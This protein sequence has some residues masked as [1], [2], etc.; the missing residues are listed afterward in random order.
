VRQIH[1]ER[2]VAGRAVAILQ[3]IHLSSS[4]SLL[5]SW[6]ALT[7]LIIALLQA[8]PAGELEIAGLREAGPCLAGQG[9]LLGY[10]CGILWYAGTSLLDLR[11]DGVNTAGLSAAEALLALFLSVAIWVSITAC[12]ALLVTL[13][14]GSGRDFRRPL[15]MAPFL[16]GG[17]GTG[18]HPG[19]G[20]SRESAGIAQVDN[21]ALCRINGVD[22]SLRDLAGD[23]AGEYCAGRGISGSAGDSGAPCWSPPWLR[24]RSCRPGD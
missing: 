8:R 13:L 4:R 19:D 3:V 1:F 18:A 20:G 24:Q 22:G 7:P 12:S 11:H 5:L 21:I 10:V 16:M 23:C 14:A 2:L 6:F 17:R 9:F 15:V